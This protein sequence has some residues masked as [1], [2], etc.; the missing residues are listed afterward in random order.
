[1]KK[2]KSYNIAVI[3]IFFAIMLVIHF[4]TIFIFNLWPVPIRPTIVH[5]PVIIA[6]IIYGPRIGATLGGLMGLLSMI[7]NTTILMPS[8]YLFSPFVEHGNLASLVIAF[9]PRI[10]I[11][12]FPYYIARFLHGKLALAL[13]GAVGSVTNT[14]FVLLGIYIFFGHFYG[15][16]FKNLLA[17]ILSA[18]SLVELIISIILTLAIVPVLK[19]R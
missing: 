3:A 15:N 8:S 18:N 4:L 10:L 11:G 5:I 19:Q 14:I 16:D 2:Q 12:V 1:M 9:L 7:V 6:S 17:V 13:A